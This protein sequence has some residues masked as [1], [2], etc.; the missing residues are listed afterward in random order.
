MELSKLILKAG[1]RP[2][3]CEA[4]R[5]TEKKGERTMKIKKVDAKNHTYDLAKQS[6]YIRTVEV[7]PIEYPDTK[8]GKAYIYVYYNK[9]I[10]KY[11]IYNDKR[12]EGG[13]REYH[14]T[15]YHT[16]K[17]IYQNWVKTY[18]IKA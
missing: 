8:P 16:S 17:N 6:R 9:D 14:K 5:E 18:D 15:Y 10:V 7:S 3:R 13:V 4:S 12:V 2:K 11:Y 1:N